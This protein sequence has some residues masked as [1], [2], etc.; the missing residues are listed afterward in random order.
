MLDIELDTTAERGEMARKITANVKES[1]ADT[2][3]AIRVG[4]Y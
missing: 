1:N 3:R 4:N 2:I